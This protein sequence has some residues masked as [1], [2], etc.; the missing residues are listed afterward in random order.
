MYNQFDDNYSGFNRFDPIPL[1]FH[2]SYD[3]PT[4]A[5]KVNYTGLYMKGLLPC[6]INPADGRYMDP[7]TGLYR[8]PWE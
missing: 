6:D 1:D 7:T 4:F 3:K 2:D 8:H 5:S